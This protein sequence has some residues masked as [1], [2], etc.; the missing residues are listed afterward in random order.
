MIRYISV[1]E[2]LRLHYLVLAQSGGTATIR[3]LAGIE[4]AV[5]Q[6]RMTFGGEDLY[7]TVEEKAVAIGFSLIRNHPFTDGNKRVGHAAIEVMLLLNGK[8]L[9][10]PVS[11]AELVILGVA[12]G[13]LEREALLDF[14][15]RW[16]RST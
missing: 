13:T 1:R 6:P 11:D 2:V 3:D 15:R 7:P 16:S 12:A 14:V 8:Q 10:A 9:D 5:A 4:S